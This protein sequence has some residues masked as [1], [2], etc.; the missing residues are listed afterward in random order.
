MD[1]G[2]WWAAVHG[3]TEPDTAEVT[4]HTGT[5]ASRSLHVLCPLPRLVALLLPTFQSTAR[6]S[7]G[8]LLASL[9]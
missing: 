3:V 2:A 4:A 7:L 6:A 5:L 1:R 8:E 9:L